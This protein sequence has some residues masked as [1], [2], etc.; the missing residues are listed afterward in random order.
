[1][2]EYVNIL[3]KETTNIA[4]FP[5]IDLDACMMV[6]VFQW[7]YFPNNAA[8]ASPKPRGMKKMPKGIME[9]YSQYDK[10]KRINIPM[11]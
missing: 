10:I 2:V 4:M 7:K 11:K 1:M 3:K 6:Y 9:P 8:A 5:D